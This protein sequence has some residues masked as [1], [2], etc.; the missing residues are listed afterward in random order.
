VHDL[1]HELSHIVSYGALQVHG[2]D[3]RGKAEV[4]RKPMQSG[5]AFWE[6]SPSDMLSKEKTPAF[7]GWNEAVTE[8]MAHLVRKRL[9][10]IG[11]PL[12]EEEQDGLESSF[13][14]YPHLMIL[15]RLIGECFPAAGERDEAF[16]ELYRAYLK[17]NYDYLDK[18]D[19]R[20]PGVREI[21]HG[22]GAE[23]DDAMKAM[24]ALGY[25][26]L[27]EKFEAAGE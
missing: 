17:G 26:D 22:M 4:H 7:A 14:Y 24:R 16:K 19:E 23:F 15:Q 1:T 11:S 8:L 13:V 5:F 18:L 9:R 25:D 21:L 3:K 20:R 6:W 2:F 12:G 10:K 27:A